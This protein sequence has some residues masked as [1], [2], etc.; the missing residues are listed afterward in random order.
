MVGVGTVASITVVPAV[1]VLDDELIDKLSRSQV[2]GSVQLNRTIFTMDNKRLEFLFSNDL[3]VSV[4]DVIVL[5]LETLV[6]VFQLD[7]DFSLRFILFQ[8]LEERLELSVVLVLLLI[9]VVKLLKSVI[10]L[11]LATG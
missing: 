8:D 2:Q 11:I 9:L 5:L 1:Q 7:G 10:E 6:L 3:V 4:D